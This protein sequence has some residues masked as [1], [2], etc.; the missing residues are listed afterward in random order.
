[1]PPKVKK[2]CFQNEWLTNEEYSNWV[3][4]VPKNRSR[5]KCSFCK[6]KIDIS[7][8]SVAALDSHAA[9]KKHKLGFNIYCSSITIDI[10]PVQLCLCI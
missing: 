4:A 6:T 10:L 7:N 1:M 2:C 8:M 9:G 3:Q 5:V